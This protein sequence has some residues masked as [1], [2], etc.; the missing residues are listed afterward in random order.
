MR[1]KPYG[2]GV[3]ALGLGV[4]SAQAQIEMTWKLS[5]GRTLLMEPIRAVVS[6]EN[7]SGRDLDLTPRGNAK[8]GFSV[9]DQPTSTVPGTGNP[10]VRRPVIIPTGETREVEVNLLDGYRI[11]KGQSYMLTPVLDYGGMRFFGSRRSLEVQPGLELF[12]R[13][14]GLRSAGDAR[15]AFLRLLHRDRSDRLFFRLDDPESGFCLGVYELGRVIRF[16]PPAVVLAGDGIF[17]ILHQSSPD[18]FM[19]SRFGYDGEPLGVTFYTAQAGQIQLVRNADGTVEVTGGAAY[20]EDPDHPGIL[21]GPAL[22]PSHPYNQSLGGEPAGTKP[23]PAAVEPSAADRKSSE[24]PAKE[25]SDVGSEP[26]T[27]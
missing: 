8:L 12:K 21:M 14:Y 9:E 26:V 5:Q 25:K 27:W 6:I 3:V 22:P 23:A 16:F 13:D 11:L 24:K 2:W 4:G 19:Q 15:T 20:V 1:W 18:R 17:H 7:N 10:L